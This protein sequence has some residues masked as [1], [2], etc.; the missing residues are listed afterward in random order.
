MSRVGV[1]ETEFVPYVVQ[2]VLPKGP[3]KQLLTLSH[4]RHRRARHHG[5]T[6]G[7][8]VDLYTYDLHR[9]SKR[10]T[11]QCTWWGARSEGGQWMMTYPKGAYAD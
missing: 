11:R 5:R 8:A 6:S 2:G 3:R 1:T 7:V 9:V 4:R 10:S